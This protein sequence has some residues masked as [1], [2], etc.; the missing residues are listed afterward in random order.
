[1]AKTIVITG[2]AGFVGAN[3]AIFLKNKY[4]E[5]SII[6]VD[7]LKRRGSD[8]NI[9]RLLDNQVKF[10]HG[11]IRNKEDFDGLPPC[12][13]LIE[14]AAEPSVLA[15]VNS[16]PGYVINT[17]LFGTINCLNYIKKHNAGLIFLSTSR[18]YPIAK[19]EQVKYFEKE[20]RF[21]ITDEQGLTGVSVHGISE[22]FPLD[23]ARSLY[24]ATKLAS[25]L[26][27]QEYM[28]MYGI[29]AV[30]NRC[31][32]IAGPWQMGKVD[33]GVVALWL[34]KH[35][36]KDKLNYIGYGGEAKQIRDIL[37]I[38][39]LLNLIDYQIHNFNNV[40]GEVFNIGGGPLNTVSLQELTNYCRKITGNSIEIGKLPDTRPGDI[41]LYVTN[42]EKIFKKTEWKVQKSINDILN[43]TYI[44]ILNN[45]NKLKKIFCL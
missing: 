33:Q 19:I 25:E 22:N 8:L 36:W 23:G 37:H 42:N 39:D 5:Y 30:I 32:V 18:V 12:D 31:G 24:G 3:I 1:M 44:W 45:E 14:A 7:N 13:Y 2:G 29:G 26:I 27:I 11:D 35:Y 15:G 41:R 4:K 17:N 9:P 34:V 10:I 16:S 21:E 38:Y 43:D 40:E 6:S 20:S 28:F